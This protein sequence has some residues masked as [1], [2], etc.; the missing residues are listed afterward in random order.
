MNKDKLLEL[1][2][3]E[4]CNILVNA[5]EQEIDRLVIYTEKGVLSGSLAYRCVYGAMTGSC[6][7]PRA[8][9]LIKAC[10]EGVFFDGL[11]LPK[12]SRTTECIRLLPDY[13][14]AEL[15]LTYTP[16]EVALYNH[17]EE[18]ITMI[19]SYLFPIESV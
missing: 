6:W 10:T 18:V 1:A 9:E 16:L 5:T 7:S 3:T 12:A 17:R 2:E 13:C 19:K 8:T 11:I 14:P 4:F 15:F